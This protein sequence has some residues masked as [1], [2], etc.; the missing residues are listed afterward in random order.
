M[1]NQVLVVSLVSCLS[2]GIEQAGGAAT[3]ASPAAGAAPGQAVV[4][5]RRIAL[6]HR[7][8]APSP[9]PAQPARGAESPAATSE[10][11]AG[12]RSSAAG[13]VSSPPVADISPAAE[14]PAPDGASASRTD[15]VL[16]SV[17]KDLSRELK[18][19]PELA[20]IEDPCRKT[21]VKTAQ[22]A[23]ATAISAHQLASNRIIAREDR[24]T[25]ESSMYAE[26]W[27]S[28][29]IVLSP[30][31]RASANAIWAKKIDGMVMVSVA[32]NCNCRS[33]PDGGK[34][35]EF[36]FVMWGKSGVERGFD[37]QS[38]TEVEYWLGKM[39]GFDV[40]SSCCGQ[41]QAAKKAAPVPVNI[42]QP[43]AVPSGPEIPRVDRVSQIL[44]E[45]GLIVIDG[46][47]FDGV[48]EHDRVIV[49]GVHDARV[50]AASPVQLKAELPA[51][52]AAGP[53]NVSVQTAGLRSNPGQF[54][55]V[56]LTVTAAGRGAAKGR[57]SR[58][59]VRA[60]GTSQPLKV[61]LINHTPDVVRIGKGTDVVVTTSGGANN[62]ASLP[63]QRLRAG[64]FKIEARPD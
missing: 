21:A 39:N 7:S 12:A 36:V 6:F 8:K 3:P 43:L 23:L 58:I 62:A 20:K 63:V 28:G 37:I 57:P 44:V 49:D 15:P 27:D 47:S 54:A 5:P 22:R 30:D 33:A 40:D 55:L 26:S 16:M 13:E 64:A 50:L 2:L 18:D 19:S 35:G 56:T 38:Q 25:L 34:L 14:P 17:L 52:L 24:Q 60:A 31:C 10:G 41:G 61:R 9:A 46:H 51:G 4:L 59:E 11:E 42:L 1:R 29:E 45:G 48:A 53:H 32:G